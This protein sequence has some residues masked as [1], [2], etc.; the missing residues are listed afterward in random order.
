MAWD[1]DDAILEVV[2]NHEEQ[3]S[4]WPA[5]RFP[6]WLAQGRQAGIEGRVPGVDRRGLDGH[7]TALA[8]PRNG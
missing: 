5:D 8:A 3:Y 2:V 4:I 6:G 1:D 7:A